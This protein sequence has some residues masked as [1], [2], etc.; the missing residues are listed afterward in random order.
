ML[1]H[2]ESSEISKTSKIQNMSYSYNF[3]GPFHIYKAVSNR[4]RRY[5]DLVLIPDEVD[6]FVNVCNGSVV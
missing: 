5:H 1:L 6:H 2:L 3:P 4:R